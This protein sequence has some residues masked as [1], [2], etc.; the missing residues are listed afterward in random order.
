MLGRG[1]CWGALPHT[2]MSIF[3]LCSFLKGNAWSV[4]AEHI[5]CRILEVSL[6]QV[7][8]GVCTPNLLSGQVLI[9]SWALHFIKPFYWVCEN[10]GTAFSL[11]FQPAC[12]CFCP[13]PPGSPVGT[14]LPIPP[15]QELGSH[16]SKP[17][18]R[19]RH[20]LGSSGS[21]EMFPARRGRLT[22]SWSPRGAGG[23]FTPRS[24]RV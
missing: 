15:E 3:L 4:F 13:L 17:Q 1:A 7:K 10:N 16:R 20:G 2:D 19:A 6:Y 11:I 23:S 21:P 5:C 8:Q 14:K 12:V 18:T 9:C 22:R 24:G